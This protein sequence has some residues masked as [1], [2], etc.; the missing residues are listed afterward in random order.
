M[1]RPRKAGQAKA[2]QVHPDGPLTSI[3][4]EDRKRIRAERERRGWT[5]K[6][7][8][9]KV[10]V[11]SGTISNLETGERHPQVRAKVLARIQRVLFHEDAANGSG[12]GTSEAFDA[13]VQGAIDLQ[14]RE[15]AAVLEFI[16]TLKKLR[17]SGG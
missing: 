14:A 2:G 3:A 13:I 15:Q 8:A 7:L 5:Q 6:E 17:H 12:E 9:T 1:S 11:T 10:G 16:A 4:D